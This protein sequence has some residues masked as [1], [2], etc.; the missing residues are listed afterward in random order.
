MI[1]WKHI[2]ISIESFA[3]IVL[4]VV[5]CVLISVRVGKNI[6]TAPM[7]FVIFGLLVSPQILNKER[8]IQ[9]REI[10]FSTMVITLLISVFI[11]GLTALPWVS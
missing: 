4:F 8:G 11:H 6:I 2:E 3:I 5:G 7:V 1:K 10:I 9:G